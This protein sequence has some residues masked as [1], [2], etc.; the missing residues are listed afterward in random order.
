MNTNIQWYNFM[1]LDVHFESKRLFTITIVNFVSKTNLKQR[2]KCWSANSYT[3]HKKGVG[4]LHDGNAFLYV[5]RF[6]F[7]ITANFNKAI[8]V[9]YM[10]MKAT[11][12]P[13]GLASMKRDIDPVIVI[14]LNG[15]SFTAH[16][17][18]LYL[19]CNGRCLY[20]LYNI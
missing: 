14:T 11:S 15:I 17:N 19:L 3:T 1:V 2:F 16:S 7:F 12:N 10:P 8:Y 4:A 6:P 5:E 13:L 20:M 9:L 18:N